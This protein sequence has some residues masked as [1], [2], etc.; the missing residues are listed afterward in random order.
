M[1]RAGE[2]GE[3]IADLV[4]AGQICDANLAHE[5]DLQ[6]LAVATEFGRLDVALL[7]ELFLVPDRV[8]QVVQLI[9]R[10]LDVLDVGDL[11]EEALI[12]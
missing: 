2:L 6:L 7:F 3:V 8:L 1:G 9:G 10:R 4:E 12:V 11:A 5:L